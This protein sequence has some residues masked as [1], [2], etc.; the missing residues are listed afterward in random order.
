M[1]R[2]T[3]KQRVNEIVDYLEFYVRY[4]KNERYQKLFEE[5]DRDIKRILEKEKQNKVNSC[6]S[7]TS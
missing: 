3:R 1:K 2:K 5:I 4:C 6:K 7:G